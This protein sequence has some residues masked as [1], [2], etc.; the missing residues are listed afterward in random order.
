L[1][2]AFTEAPVLHHWVPDRQ[3]TVETDASIASILSITGDNGKIH[4]VLFRSR[5][6]GPSELNYDTHDKELLAIFDAF[7]QWRHYL[8]GAPL[9]IDVV[10]DHKNL[11]YF[12]TTKVLTCCQLQWSEYLCH[13]N[14]AIQFR[15]GKLRGKP[16]AL[17]R[18]RDIYPKEGDR[19]YG[20]LNPQN[21]RPIFTQDQIS[22]SLQAT[23]L[24][25]VCLRTSVI[26]DVEKLHSDIRHHLDDDP[27]AVAGQRN[28]A[29]LR[30]GLSTTP[31]YS[32]LMS[33]STFR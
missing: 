9:P 29:H 2:R 16:D 4:P 8:E 30:V 1:K 31:D 25:D 14:M 5:S 22:A 7:T 33:E 15:L 20:R 18:R 32:N 12:A 17:I 21:F 23:Y 11:E 27:A 19:A 24:K 13:F 3:I 6:L 10:T 26:V 28:P